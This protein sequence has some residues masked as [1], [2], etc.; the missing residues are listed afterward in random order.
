MNELECF[1]KTFVKMDSVIFFDDLRGYSNIKN[2]FIDYKVVNHS[3]EFVSSTTGTHIN[4]I[5]GCWSA[6]KISVSFRHRTRKLIDI[7]LLRFMINRNEKNDSFDFFIKL[8][9]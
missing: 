4:T 8:I 7:Y 2:F 6:I 9:F 5:E 3:K 1:L